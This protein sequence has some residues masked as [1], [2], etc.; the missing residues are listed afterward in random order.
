[1]AGLGEMQQLTAANPS[2]P[3]LNQHSRRARRSHR[4]GPTLAHS[5]PSLLIFSNQALGGNQI[6]VDFAPRF[7]RPVSKLDELKARKFTAADREHRIARSLA[8]LHEPAQLHLSAVDWQWLDE[9]AD[10]ENEFD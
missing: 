3:G 7:R 8:A 9:H 1:M 10:A 4:G 5:S 2:Q 6:S